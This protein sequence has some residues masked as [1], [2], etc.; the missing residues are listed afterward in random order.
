MYATNKQ[1]M[2]WKLPNHILDGL[3]VKVTSTSCNCRLGADGASIRPF[4]RFL[5]G[6]ARG[7]ASHI[8]HNDLSHIFR[9]GLDYSYGIEG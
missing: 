5:I 1:M 2:E 9:L 4:N 6:W 3:G 7:K 8:R